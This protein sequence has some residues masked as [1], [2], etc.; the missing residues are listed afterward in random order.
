MFDDYYHTIKIIA[1]TKIITDLLSPYF[2]SEILNNYWISGIKLVDHLHCTPI[3]QSHFIIVPTVSAQ[4]ERTGVIQC[5]CGDF[6][7]GE[8]EELCTS[9]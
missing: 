2:L 5:E 7:I 9:D 6:Y 4:D 3:T 1:H 8:Q